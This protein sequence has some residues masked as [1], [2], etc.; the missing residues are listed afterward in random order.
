MKKHGLIIGLTA[1]G[2]LLAGL[3]VFLSWYIAISPRGT[4]FLD[5]VIPESDTAGNEALVYEENV[6]QMPEGREQQLRLM[7]RKKNGEE[8]PLSPLQLRHLTVSSSNPEVLSVDESGKMTA[9]K[10]GEAQVQ[11]VLMKQ[12]TSFSVEV[13]KPLQGIELK[14]GD[15]TMIVGDEL[16]AGFTIV[17]EDA[18]LFDT[19][20][21]TSDHE[22]VISVDGDCRMTALKKGEA[23]IRASLGG[24]SAEIGILSVIPLEGIRFSE[25]ELVKNVG[26]TKYMHIEYIPDNATLP[27]KVSYSVSDSG[28]AYI[29]ENGV[30]K[31]LAPGTVK[32]YADADGI[33]AEA[34]VTIY[35][36]LQGIEV[37][38]ENI[39]L[40]GIGDSCETEVRHIPENTTDDRSLRFESSDETVASVDELGVITAAGPGSC[41]ITTYCG[42]F[43]AVSH[44]KV[45]IPLESISFGFDALT[46]HCGDSVTLP[47]G[48]WPENT[49]VD[50]TLVWES[51]DPGVAVA[52]ENGTVTAV[53]AGTCVITASCSGC[54]AS[55]TITVDIP[56]TGVAIS[57]TAATINKGTSLKLDASVIPPNTTESPYITWS[58]DNVNVAVV[59]ENGVV[60]GVGAGTCTITANHDLI[61]ATC[62][63]TVLSPLTGIYF[64]QST[65]YLIEGYGGKLTVGYDPV[66]TTDD[67]TVTWTSENPEIAT[68]DASGNVAAVKA[69]SVR[70]R[71]VC[72]SQGAYADVHV[73]PFIKVDSVSLDKTGVSFR[74]VGETVQL[75]AAVQP[76]N[77]TIPQVS[78]SSSDSSVAT[79]N[80]S[81]LVTAVGSGECVIKASSG[82]KSASCTVR[83]AAKNRV[84]VLDPGHCDRFR[85]AS[86]N[87]LLEHEIN[88]KTAYYCKEYLESHYA[89]VTVY[90]TRYDHSNLADN[91]KA[92]LE[93]R[94]Q[95]AQDHQADILVSLHFNA[96]VNHNARGC[97]AFV[98]Y[99]PNVASQSA[100]LANQILARISALGIQN[101][102]LVS[103]SSN[104]YFDDFGN[105]LDYYAINRHCANRGIPGII[106]EHC[107]LDTEPQFCNSDAKLQ[108]LGIADAQGIAAY[109]GLP[110]K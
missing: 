84:V 109:L 105:P 15:V 75:H 1:G 37:T 102:G 94:A 44:V 7:R 21:F 95:V 16:S 100:A 50:R 34:E 58:S 51:S 65:L 82:G 47:V 89:G 18:K 11:A 110:A 69:G 71:A 48:Y 46:I 85:G 2:I 22:E 54:T 59:D 81:G 72:G 56:V 35:A 36:P 62:T 91:L 66:D 20:V 108:T 107:F 28:L 103:A 78:W 17:P 92:D 30:L 87:G 106:V 4:V 52:D 60:T 76:K 79:V 77:A 53:G 96:T 27:E 40:V 55:V 45:E 23:K 88:L 5:T 63:M 3:A 41:D 32:V 19:P 101:L 39:V 98:S 9:L 104:Q 68:V 26:E 86:Y 38:K 33:R 93:A 14:T 25:P 80:G 12:E 6:L 57:Q 83:V 29:K 42:D 13:Y 64:E 61:G 8:V 31:V 24:Y 90:M 99:Q 97:L 73:S 43:S 70:I 67:R 49:T 74:V 10:K